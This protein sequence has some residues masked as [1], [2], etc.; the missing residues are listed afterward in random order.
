MSCCAAWARQTTPTSASGTDG[1]AEFLLL[2]DNTSKLL[3]DDGVSRLLLDELVIS[4]TLAATESGSDTA[5]ASGTVHPAGTM[6]ATET[7]ADTFSSSGTANP[8]VS[9]SMAAS[10]T[11][12]DA[13]T[14][15]GT[16]G[17]VVAAGQILVPVLARRRRGR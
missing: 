10:E 11:G 17:A 4:G 1:V 3:L 13:F 8:P 7:G 16:S 2:D 6:A 15:S 9:G 14:A 5:S 12:A